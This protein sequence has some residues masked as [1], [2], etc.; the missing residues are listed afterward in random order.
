M[1][2]R[3]FILLSSMTA[4]A[5]SIPSINCRRRNQVLDKTLAQPFLL[6]HICDAK[7]I[8]AI[9]ASYRQNLKTEE[10]KDQF[11]D[12]LLID[13][14]GKSVPES[15]DISFIQTLLEQKIRKDFKSGNTVTVKGFIISTTEAR[16]CALFSLGQ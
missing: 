10:T 3:N 4:A 14:L 8:Q 1:K 16:Q 2:R 6:S 9:G 13:T 12:L 11:V 5:I 15:S 7:T